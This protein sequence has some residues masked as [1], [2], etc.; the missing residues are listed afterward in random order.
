MRRSEEIGTQS[1]AQGL[2]PP[3]YRDRIALRILDGSMPTVGIK[4]S[5]L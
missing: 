2:A 1:L 4:L 3:G 5:Y